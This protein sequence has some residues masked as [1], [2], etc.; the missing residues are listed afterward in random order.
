[1][2]EQGF[3]PKS[4]VSRDCAFKHYFLLPLVSDKNCNS[5]GAKMRE[6]KIS[7]CSGR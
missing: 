1:M 4:S 7:D 6:E 3:K 2:A 5:E